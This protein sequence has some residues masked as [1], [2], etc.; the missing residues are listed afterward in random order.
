MRQAR[1]KEEGQR[2]DRKTIETAI[3]S[4]LLSVTVH[5]RWRE[6]ESLMLTEMS[7]HVCVQHSDSNPDGID[8]DFTVI[9]TVNMLPV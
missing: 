8:S 3:L 6:E 7:L 2:T 4:S 1:W 9:K 5:N